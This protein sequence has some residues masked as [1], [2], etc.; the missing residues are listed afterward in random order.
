MNQMVHKAQ[1]LQHIHANKKN[2]YALNSKKQQRY[3][4]VKKDT[5][6]KR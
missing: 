2:I 6:I 5:K 4:V 1:I 3:E